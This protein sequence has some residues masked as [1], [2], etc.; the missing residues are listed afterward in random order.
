MNKEYHTCN[1]INKT[2]SKALITE[3]SEKIFH[4]F[5]KY[6]SPLKM[7][8]VLLKCLGYNLSRPILFSE[9]YKSMN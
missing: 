8:I 9:Y 3:D 7:D 1:R 4:S 2:S 5:N 6:E